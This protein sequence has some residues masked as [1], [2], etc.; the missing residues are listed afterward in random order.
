MNSPLHTTSH[1]SS[2][3]PLLVQLEIL[4]YVI[5]NHPCRES[6]VRAATDKKK[7][8][9]NSE[10]ESGNM[11]RN[12]NGRRKRSLQSQLEDL[13]SDE[14]EK[15][16]QVWRDLKVDEEAGLTLTLTLTLIGSEGR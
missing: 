10:E 5:R 14:D 12:G 4:I 6:V 8:L 11:E 16:D 13:S 9:N 3:T 15:A 1:L 2:P 7:P